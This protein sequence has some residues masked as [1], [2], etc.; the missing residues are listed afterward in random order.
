MAVRGDRIEVY[1]VF[2]AILD[3]DFNFTRRVGAG[4]RSDFS[5]GGEPVR[6]LGVGEH[7]RVIVDN[8]RSIAR[9]GFAHARERVERQ[10]RRQRMDAAVGVRIDGIAQREQDG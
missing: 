3:R 1:T 6:D 8:E 2:A 7:E 5:M 10:G 9:N 4:F